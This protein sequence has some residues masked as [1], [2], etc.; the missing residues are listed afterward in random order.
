MTANA[1]ILLSREHDS[2]NKFKHLSQSEDESLMSFSALNEDLTHNKMRYSTEHSE[3]HKDQ[4][5]PKR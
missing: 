2:K 5:Q 3:D 1:L 4:I